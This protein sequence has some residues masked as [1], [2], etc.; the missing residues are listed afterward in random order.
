M[1]AMSERSRERRGWCRW[2]AALRLPV[3]LIVRAGG[4][5]WSLVD[6]GGGQC[7]T[8]AADRASATLHLSSK[9]YRGLLQTERP[10]I[11][12]WR[13]YPGRMRRCV[14]CAGEIMVPQVSALSPQAVACS[15]LTTRLHFWLQPVAQGPDIRSADVVCTLWDRTGR[16][17]HLA[18]RVG[19]SGAFSFARG[20]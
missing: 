9:R 19:I 15:K 18:A 17:R 11:I 16:G 14:S 10:L 5:A 12:G 1:L 13:V 8:D 20:Y 6:R 2:I 3:A 4:Q 7:A